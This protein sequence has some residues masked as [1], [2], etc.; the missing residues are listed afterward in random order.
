MV[1]G[2]LLTV[3]VCVP[4]AA[5]GQGRD[6]AP[7]GE[8][9]WRA[10]GRSEAEWA[11]AGWWNSA[12]FYEVFVRSF[13]DSTA[14]PLAGD[15][16]G[17]LRG[18]IERLDYLNDGDAATGTD[19]GVTGLWLM[20]IHPSSKYHG[21]DVKD[22][23]GVHPELGTM[24]DFRGLLG[25]CHARGI[26]VVLDL[27]V[28]H[29]SWE[30]PWFVEAS[31][32]AESPFRDW[33]IW[34][35]RVPDW[36]GLW[37]QAVWWRVGTGPGR[38]VPARP[39]DSAGPFYFGMF[40]WTMPDLNYRTEAVTEAM[41]DVSRF[42]LSEVGVDGFR[43]DAI[44]H[45]I[46]EGRVQENTP[47]THG[48]LERFRGECRRARG[49]AFTI[50]EV[51]SPTERVAEYVGRGLD[52]AFEF[53][54][55]FAMVEAARTGNAERFVA[56]QRRTLDLL[57]PGQYG[58]FLTNHD[59]ARVMT[60]LRGDEGATRVA[61]M[62]LLLGP[63]VPFVYYGEEIGMSGD[64]PDER[65]RTPM[66]W[67]G[68]PGGGFTTGTAWQAPQADAGSRHVAAQDG[69]PGSLLSLYRRLIR[70]RSGSAALSWGPTALLACDHPSVVA[71]VRTIPSHPD[72]GTLVLVNLGREAVEG[73]SLS[74]SASIAGTMRG[75]ERLVGLGPVAELRCGADGSIAGYRPIGRLEARSG[76]VIEWSGHER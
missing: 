70:L 48:W 21:Y 55:S 30:H 73:Y 42:W 19:L 41:V 37:D 45:L 46:E 51:W 33:F 71:F 56:A 18:L 16:V 52:A 3:L 38:V 20:P 25:A 31:R 53:D 49:D 76:Y 47:A 36:R 7:V 74:G 54:L 32:G 66:Q 65:I 63:G 39:G 8:P 68:G 11:R 9:A 12:V 40:H 23:K 44:R 15:G 1:R 2:A 61:A 57:P 17:D 35:E 24:E 62:L 4:A 64:K 26:R 14:G 75:V 34:T 50:G 5:L 60:A 43:L 59:Q 58:R 6:P 69:D 28:N 67:S 27:V 13:A 72:R 10:L 29:V 22:F